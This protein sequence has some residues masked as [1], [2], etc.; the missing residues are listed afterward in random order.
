MDINP[1]SEIL[2]LHNFLSCKVLQSHSHKQSSRNKLSSPETVYL[3]LLF[4]SKEAAIARVPQNTCL[5]QRAAITCPHWLF[6]FGVVQILSLTGSY[7]GTEAP[8]DFHTANHHDS[9]DFTTDRVHYG[10][11]SNRA[12][13]FACSDYMCYR[14]SSFN[15]KLYLVKNKCSLIQV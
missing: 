2:L 8:V 5:E 11:H 3:D 6:K 4:L 12:L 1:G 9:L 14:L 10:T 7:V 15:F 13:C